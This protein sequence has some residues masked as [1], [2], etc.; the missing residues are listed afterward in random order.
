[1]KKG[2]TK[3]SKCIL[4]KKVFDCNFFL[5]SFFIILPKKLYPASC[6]VA[7]QLVVQLPSRVVKLPSRV[8]QLPSRVAQLPSRVVHLPSRIAQ[9]P[10]RVVQL[11]SSVIGVPSALQSSG[12]TRTTLVGS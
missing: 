4:S 9:L 3:V 5:F 11:L 1:M 8:A 6:S 7:V 2:H 10:S 12:R